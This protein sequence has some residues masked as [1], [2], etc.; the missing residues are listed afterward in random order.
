MFS[1]RVVIVVF[2]FMAFSFM[3]TSS[4]DAAS[5]QAEKEMK[6]TDAMATYVI[7]FSYTQKGIEK[8]KGSPIRVEA[9][10]QTIKDMGG[11]VKAFY[12]IMGGQYDTLFVVKAPN[13]E[14]IAKMVLAIGSVGNVRTDT[15]RVFT[16]E[17]FR[18]IVSALP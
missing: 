9:A 16:E 6:G 8:I 1:L 7:F 12:A 15:H 10:R 18:K 3:N 14:A 2:S 17:E 5:S 13:D 4:S 11:E